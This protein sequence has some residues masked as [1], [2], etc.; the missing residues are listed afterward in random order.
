VN[1][2][3]GPV[4][5]GNG[6][7]QVLLGLLPVCDKKR[8]PVAD[9]TKV[10]TDAVK[11]E[12]QLSDEGRTAYKINVQPL[13]PT[14]VISGSVTINT[15]DRN[16]T[17]DLQI[18]DG[19]TG[20]LIKHVV[21]RD[22]SG[23]LDGFLE[24]LGN[25]VGNFAC[26]PAP[27]RPQPKKKNKP[28]SRGAKGPIYIRLQLT[29]NYDAA[30]N[31]NSM[32]SKTSEDVVVQITAAD[33]GR[34]QTVSGAPLIR[35][36][37]LSAETVSG[38]GTCT[39]TGR[40]SNGSGG[41]LGMYKVGRKL[42]GG[43]PWPGFLGVAW[44]ETSTGGATSNCP[45]RASFNPLFAGR[46]TSTIEFTQFGDGLSDMDHFDNAIFPLTNAATR[47]QVFNVTLKSD[48]KF[49]AQETYTTRASG[50]IS[51]SRGR[52]PDGLRRC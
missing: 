39:W 3:S 20:R 30:S 44:D 49:S 18:T 6:S 15:A 35:S 27:G 34:G 25:G 37:S 8:E 42:F 33:L 23:D 21:V 2:G 11:T 47:S 41:P 13:Q 52:C 28:P 4:K 48:T 17:S 10:A 14:E 5:V 43:Y 38:S 9:R 16:A 24:R 26:P 22:D 31:G 46:P 40:L 32:S 19:R 36:S 45:S 50:R 51:I 7:N 12:Q 1:D 29:E